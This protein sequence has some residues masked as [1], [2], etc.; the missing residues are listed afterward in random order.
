[1]SA[2]LTMPAP[3]LWDAAQREI[4]AA[5]GLNVYRCADPV[6]APAANAPATTT[7]AARSSAPALSDDPLLLALL[8]AAG[9]GRDAEDA[10]ELTQRW[11]SPQALRRD[12]AAKRAIW[13][14]LRALRRRPP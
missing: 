14:Q 4:L 10:A 1:M 2:N 12:P 8:R 11:P 3:V 13:P 6:A 7:A 9:R 5:M